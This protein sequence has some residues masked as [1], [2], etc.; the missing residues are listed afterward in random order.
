M[1]EDR[2]LLDY[3]NDILES[4]ADIKEFT[5]GMT[6]EGFSVDKKTISNLNKGRENRF[7]IDSSLISGCCIP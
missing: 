5:A 4:L 6:R 2:L 3:L 1:S 7:H